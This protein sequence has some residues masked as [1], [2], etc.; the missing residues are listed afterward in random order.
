[1]R[2]IVPASTT[3]HR[4]GRPPLTREFLADIARWARE[5]CGVKSYHDYI[6]ERVQE[7]YG[8]KPQRDTVKVWIK[9]C[10]DPNDLLGDEAI[11]PDELRRSRTPRRPTGEDD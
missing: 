11:G 7:H 8:W 1:M 5:G 2:R 10:K 6:I 4:G 3:E 9:R